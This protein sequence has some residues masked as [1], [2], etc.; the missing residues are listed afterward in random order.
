MPYLRKP[1]ILPD[2][3]L[4]G[5]YYTYSFESI[6]KKIDYSVNNDGLL[7]NKKGKALLSTPLTFDIETSSMPENDPH[8]PKE[9]MLGFPYLYQLYLLDTVFFC[10][11]QTECYMLFSEIERV[12]LKHNIQAVCYVHNLSFEYQFL[13]SI[14]NIDFTKVFLVKNRKVAKF[15]LNSDTIIFRD[16]YLLSNMSLAKFCENYNSVEYQKDK[17][18]IDYEIIRY[19]WSELSNEILYYSGMDVITLY[20]AVMSIMA[21]EG[22]NLKTIPMTNTGYVRRS[23]KKACLGSTY[24]GGSYRAKSEAKFKQKKTYRQK[25][26]DKEKITLEQYNLLLKAFRG[27]NT[28]ANRYKVGRIISNVTSY[29]FASSYP[30][31]MICSDQFPSGRLMECTNSVQTPDGI[32]YYIKNY[33]CIFEAVFEDVQLRDN[34]KTPVPYI[35]KSKMICPT[36]A[37]NTGIFDNGRLISQ[38]ES[39]EF[40]FLGCEYA[41]IKNQYVGKMKI[42]KAYYTTKGYL[43]DEIRK[44]CASW[45][46]KKTELK[47]IEGSE[48]EYMKSKNRV[49]ASFGMMVEKIVKDISDFSGNLNEL[50]LRTPTEEEAKNQIESYYNVRSGK[51]LNYQWG[52][53]V[54][55]LARVRLQELIDLTYK[56]FIYADTDSVK[57]E[58]GEKYKELLENYNKQWIEYAENCNVSFKAYTKKGDLQ[59]LGIADFDGFYK[60]FTTL[61]AKKYAYDDENDQLHIT[62]AGVP[63]K[64]G[65][66]LLGKIENFKV[67]MHFM[68]G[69]DGTLE[70]R[71]AWKKR[72]LYNDTDNFDLTIDGNILHIGTYIA[73]ERTSY[74]LSI[75][76]EYEELISSLKNDEIYEKD[77]IWG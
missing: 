73:M 22:D 10:R 17:E 51:F 61:G 31:V 39:F 57:I 74:E 28:H 6:E 42:T 38:K 25:Y 18:L 24:N 49:N 13:K 59:I 12:L 76:D 3:R 72:L 60:R 20:H 2:S 5:F 58:N 36:S 64:L 63:K 34:I 11:T 29:D 44:E 32:D 35:P 68:V 15:E 53:T 69:A 16:S 30:A 45:Y 48:Y 77:D 43:P 66:K 50:T 55:A 70:D 40:S 23:Y 1:D 46:T 65:A 41:I 14:L 37:Y 67:G 8:N 27:G 47:G 75:T 26:M 56:D 52:V 7:L 9:Y 21:K 62:I 4:S 19:P 54:T 71:Q 33:W